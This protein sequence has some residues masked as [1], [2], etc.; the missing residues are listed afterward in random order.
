M[1]AAAD[2]NWLE[3]KRVRRA[4]L[5]IDVVESVRL[6]KHDEAN[7]IDRW[8]RFV[9]EVR[10]QVLPTWGG[11]LVKHLGDGM[12]MTFDQPALAVGCS[13][14]LQQRIARL[15]H[16]RE[17]NAAIHLRAGVH[18]SEVVEDDV[19]IYGSGVN[20]CAR[21]AALARAGEVV[22]SL[23]VRDGLL[24]GFDAE[25]E[26]LGE[27]FLKHLDEPVRAY[28]LQPPGAAPWRSALQP[29][30]VAPPIVVLPFVVTGAEPALAAGA[31]LADDLLA[32]L[33]RCGFLQPVARLAATTGACVGRL[34]GLDFAR[35]VGAE[36]MVRARADLGAE[37]AQVA[38]EVLA[39]REQAV[40]AQGHWSGRATALLHPEDGLARQLTGDIVTALLQRH[41]RLGHRAAF[42]NLPSYALLLSSIARVHRLSAMDFDVAKRMLDE[43]VDRNPRSP[44]AHCWLAKWHFFQVNQARAAEPML[45]IARARSQ[46]RRALD[47][48]DR[49]VLSLSVDGHLDAFVERDLASAERKLRLAVDVAPHEP[50]A[51]LFLANVYAH[52]GR[53][54][55]AVASVEQAATLSPLD[56]MRFMYDLFAST[57]YWAA[58]RHEQALRHAE[59]SVAQNAL[60]LSA[61]VQLIVTQVGAGHLDDAR[62]SAARYLHL[63]P[64]ASV[65]LYRDRHMAAGTDFA[66]RQADA[67]LAAGLP[68]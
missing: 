51:N 68:Y 56:P 4:L 21:L 2:G 39:V 40:C 62:A 16:G 29:T 19:D 60:H 55:E 58:G 23:E 27:C 35:A 12:L 31:A 20:L 10:H 26:D 13:F 25:V 41:E 47:L 32:A 8:R 5:V 52:S 28:R 59:R 53:G 7:V 57:A 37:P 66:A 34:G 14:E 36:F 64:S 17:P 6:M 15:D 42:E 67:L 45:A 33:G 61:L 46:L 22:G 30:T 43:L 24:I 50:L 54:D 63:R 9:H 65:R 11:R 49:H 18:V 48:D 44:D 1:T 38:W 3:L